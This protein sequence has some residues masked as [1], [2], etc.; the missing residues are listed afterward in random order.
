[1]IR[2]KIIAQIVCLILVFTCCTSAF[3]MDITDISVSDASKGIV[4][5]KGNL[6]EGK[7]NRD[8]IMYISPKESGSALSDSAVHFDSAVAGKDGLFEFNFKLNAATGDYL[9]NV[10]YGDELKSNS[11]SF[12]IPDDLKDYIISLCDNKIDDIA[13]SIAKYQDMLGVKASV[14][15]TA[16]DINII[17]KRI[18]QKSEKIKSDALNYDFSLAIATIQAAAN[19]ITQLNK[20][21]AASLW[22]E[23]DNCLSNDGAVFGIDTVNHNKLSSS[24]RQSVC[25]ALA[26]RE[27]AD[28]ET[29][30]SEYDRLVSQYSTSGG[31]SSSVG[32]GGSSSKGGVKSTGGLPD[33]VPEISSTAFNDIDSVPWATDAINA[34]VKR[35]VLSGVGN[36]KFEPNREV[37]R[38]ELI[39]MIVAAFSLKN[40]GNSISFTDVMSGEWYYSYVQTGFGA[41]IVNGISEDLFGVGRSVTRQEL[42]AILYRTA[43]YIGMNFTQEKVFADNDEI[44]DYA[45]EAVSALAGNGIIDGIGDNTFA[46]N[47]TATRAQTAKLIWKLLQTKEGV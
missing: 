9:V 18:S 37:K 7:N 26:G 12:V 33:I 14:F 36:N 22:S 31:G 42:A 44:S 11:I 8:V 3:A 41:G 27:F 43:K 34:L 13:G 4:T 23:V 2:N 10:K 47:Q 15:A 35:N 6:G 38:E 24:V 32:G 25:S 21:T 40:N 29:I 19:E 17:K 1:M 45:R 20:I 46:P 30:K 39:K 5:V 28:A 16:R